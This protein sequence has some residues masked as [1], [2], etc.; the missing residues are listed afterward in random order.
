M[1]MAVVYFLV[2]EL[3]EPVKELASPTRPVFLI[4]VPVSPT[5]IVNPG[6]PKLLANAWVSRGFFESHMHQ[7]IGTI[8]YENCSIRRT[9][10][11]A[12][13]KI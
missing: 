9:I 11:N 7:Q 13:K 10:F 5:S 3:T 8:R 6:D 1:F 2:P 4:P 12:Y